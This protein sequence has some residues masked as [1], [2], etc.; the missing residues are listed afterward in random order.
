M[1][2]VVKC[3]VLEESIKGRYLSVCVGGCFSSENLILRQCCLG[4]FQVV[5]SK[6]R[7]PSKKVK[8]FRKDIDVAALASPAG[9]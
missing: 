9:L 6:N 1:N 7:C 8:M 4:C 3:K 2:G 5:M